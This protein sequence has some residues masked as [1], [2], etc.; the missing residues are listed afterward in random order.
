MAFKFSKNKTVFDIR[1]VPEE[2]R[3]MYARVDD[4][5]TVKA[6]AGSVPTYR[7]RPVVFTVKDEFWPIILAYESQAAKREKL[8]AYKDEIT[9]GILVK[10]VEDRVNGVTRCK[11]FERGYFK[12]E[13]MDPLE[14]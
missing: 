12:G 6:F 10:G 7:G 1:Q 8:Q 3:S 11:I 14:A 13:Y 2:F 9:Q 5:K 4:P